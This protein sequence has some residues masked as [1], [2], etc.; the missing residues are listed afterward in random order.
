MFGDATSDIDQQLFTGA[1]SVDIH[2]WG[3]EVLHSIKQA[4][5]SPLILQISNGAKE[6]E[7]VCDLVH[8]VSARGDL[9]LHGYNRSG[10]TLSVLCLH[11][12]KVGQDIP[13]GENLEMAHTFI[14]Q[15]FKVH[16][17]Y[18]ATD[19]RAPAWVH[20]AQKPWWREL[21]LYI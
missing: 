5:L 18:L 1:W 17:N 21:T 16:S 9:T 15:F 2:C 4:T 8:K 7:L 10:P 20:P 19:F 6:D 3:R 12:G 14:N 13:V 11:P